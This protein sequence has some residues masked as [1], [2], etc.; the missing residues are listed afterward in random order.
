MPEGIRGNAHVWRAGSP[1]GSALTR[2]QTQARILMYRT[3]APRSP[4]P[5]K[6]KIRRAQGGDEELILSDAPERLSG[7]DCHAGRD[8]S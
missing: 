4:P 2:D 6:C 8:T 5:L 3:L 7:G 1:I